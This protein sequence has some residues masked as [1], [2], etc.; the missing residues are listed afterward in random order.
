VLPEFDPAIKSASAAPPTQAQLD[1]VYCDTSDLRLLRRGVTLRF[2]R[3]EAGGNVWKASSPPTLRRSGSRAARSRFPE[4]PARCRDCCATLTRGWAFGAPLR[5]GATIR[6]TRRT[7]S[8]RD[9]AGRPIAGIDDDDVCGPRARRVT[10]RYREL[11]IELA[12]TPPA[13]RSGRSRRH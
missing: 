1:A 6:T 10:A 4:R 12:P 13:S 9:N 7:I 8:L 5:R 11:E 2:Q 3:R